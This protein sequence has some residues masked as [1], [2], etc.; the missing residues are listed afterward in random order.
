MIITKTDSSKDQ[1]TN[2]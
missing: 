2:C 1:L